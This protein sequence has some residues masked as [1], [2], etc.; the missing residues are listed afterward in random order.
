MVRNCKKM[1]FNTKLKILNIISGAKYGGAESFF[2]RLAISFAKNQDIDQ[3]I[4][5]RSNR[6]RLNK[7]KKVTNEVEQLIFFN[8]LN[9]FCSYKIQ[10]S[11]KEFDPHIVLTWMNRAS[12]LLPRKKI[13]NEITV[14]RLGGYYKIKNYTKCDFLITNTQDLKKFVISEG[15]D[16]KKVEFI[17]NFVLSS[18]SLKTRVDS[19]NRKTILCMGRF[20]E[21]KAI[22]I[23]I[24]SMPF[25]PSFKLIIVGNGLLEN[26]YRLLINKLNL[27]NRVEIHKW[28]NHIS[29]FLTNASMLICPSRH[30]PFGNIVIDGWAHKIPVVVSN[31]GGPGLIVK[32]GFNGL[33][34]Q[35]DNIFDLVNKIKMLNSDECLKKKVTTNGFKLF[36]SEYSEKV[37]VKKY[38]SFFNKIC[39]LCVE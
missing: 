27:S 38:I 8:S 23:L 17:P 34:F 30:E 26:S 19:K 31:V 9:P 20:H 15:W 28:S 3:K 33:K 25:L 36:K 10:Q 14:G 4:L 5:I 39:K 12:N 18:Q 11:I 6:E 29:N 35:K 21:N 24:K 13:N 22:D 16:R 32:H 37:I 2:E 1:G 7:L